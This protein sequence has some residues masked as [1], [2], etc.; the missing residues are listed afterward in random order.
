MRQGGVKGAQPFEIV[1][2]ERGKGAAHA[3]AKIDESN[4]EMRTMQKNAVQK[5]KS[6][7]SKLVRQVKAG[8]G[9]ENDSVRDTFLGGDGTVKLL[10]DSNTVSLDQA[11]VELAD[12]AEL[13]IHPSVRVI[14]Y[15]GYTK[16]IGQSG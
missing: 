3:D 7:D 9:S 11:T 15:T 14:Q 13:K 4:I 16:R 1:N 6:A 2:D 10:S 5:P 8:R 12:V